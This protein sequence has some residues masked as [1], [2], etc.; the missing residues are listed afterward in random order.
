VA[1]SW[2]QTKKRKKQKKSPGTFQGKKVIDKRKIS[3][4]EEWPGFGGSEERRLAETNGRGK[5][6]RA[7]TKGR[8]KRKKRWGKR[9]RKNTECKTADLNT[10]SVSPK[11]GRERKK[12]IKKKT[13]G[14]TEVFKEGKEFFKAKRFWRRT[15]S[16]SIPKGCEGGRGVTPT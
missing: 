3:L 15:A 1:K 10:D 14:E 16:G 4:N 5:N 6:D 13:I 11:V 12:V 2:L 8:I 7:K 9:G